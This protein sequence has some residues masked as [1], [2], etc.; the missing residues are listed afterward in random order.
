MKTTPR[1]EGFSL[2]ELLI[3]VAII[4]IVSS[5]AIPNLLAARRAAN[6]SSAIGNLRVVNTAQHT[7]YLTAGNGRYGAAYELRDTKLID[8]S[9]AGAGAAATGGVVNGF[10]YT[11]TPGTGTYT[12][13]AA[14]QDNRATRSFFVDESG[15][16]RYQAGTVPP[17]ATTGTPIPN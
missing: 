1:Q 11:V 5:I 6:E 17:D 10:A 3:V 16:I 9:L 14:A 12:A 15:V 7:F 2:I 13:T 8:M 4:G